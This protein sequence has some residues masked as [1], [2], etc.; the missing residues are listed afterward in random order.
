MLQKSKPT[1]V[2]KPIWVPIHPPTLAPVIPITMVNPK[3]VK[4]FF[5]PPLPNLSPTTILY[6]GRQ[7]VGRDESFGDI[8]GFQTIATGRDFI[9]FCIRRLDAGANGNGGSW[10]Q[11]LRGDIV[12]VH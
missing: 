2:P 1:A 10:G 7:A 8:F 3:Y 11:N 6:Q 12:V 5:S 9:T 4:A